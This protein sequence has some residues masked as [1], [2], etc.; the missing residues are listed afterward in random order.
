[1]LLSLCF[2]YISCRAYFGSLL[3]SWSHSGLSCYGM[4][5]LVLYNGQE[6]GSI[7]IILSTSLLTSETEPQ[8]VCGC[9]DVLAVGCVLFLSHELPPVVGLLTSLWVGSTH[10]AYPD[11]PSM[12]HNI[13]TNK[14]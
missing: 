10:G 1:M 11:T 14:P 8:C 5:P 2:S 12:T 4:L 13:Q 7:V 3:A 6:T 9:V